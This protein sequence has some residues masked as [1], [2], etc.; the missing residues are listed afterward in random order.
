MIDI[1][2]YDKQIFLGIFTVPEPPKDQLI[3]VYEQVTCKDKSYV[4]I[5]ILYMQD[6]NYGI[7]IT[8]KMIDYIKRNKI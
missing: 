4:T 6:I 8:D 3:T 7:A 5:D 1:L 2:V